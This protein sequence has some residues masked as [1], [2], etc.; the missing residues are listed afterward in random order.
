[1]ERGGE[2]DVMVAHGLGVDHA[3]HAHD[4]GSPQMRA[5]LR[6]TDAHIEKVHLSQ[7]GVVP[8]GRLAG[9]SY[10]GH[11]DVLLLILAEA[12]IDIFRYREPDD[13]LITSDPIQL[14][15]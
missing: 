8:M 14:I 1:M 4:V 3:G 15:A 9:S 10:F 5:K 6:E 13:R 12:S 2:W 7:S 11:G